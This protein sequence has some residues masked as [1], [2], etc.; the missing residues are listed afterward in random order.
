MKPATLHLLLTALLTSAVFGQIADIGMGI[1]AC[2]QTPTGCIE[3]DSTDDCPVGT[4]YSYMTGYCNEDDECEASVAEPVDQLAIDPVSAE[5]EEEQGP[6][7]TCEI[8]CNGGG[9]G[10]MFCPGTDLAACCASARRVCDVAGLQW[11]ICQGEDNFRICY[12]D[13]WWE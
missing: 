11:A 8:T 10:T 6:M 3:V 12:P 13:A 4:T 1:G 9:G 5:A 7:I 2:C